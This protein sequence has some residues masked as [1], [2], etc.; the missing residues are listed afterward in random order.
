MGILLGAMRYSDKIEKLENQVVELENQ[1]SNE[2]YIE[3]IVDDFELV[4]ELQQWYYQNNITS[5]SFGDWLQIN[6]PELYRRTES[7]F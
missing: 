4:I 5:H 7:Y 6:Y 2:E 1:P 3:Q